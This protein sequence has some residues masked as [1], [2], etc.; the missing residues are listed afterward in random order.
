ML[1]FFPTPDNWPASLPLIITCIR[2][3]H[4]SQKNYPSCCVTWTLFFSTTSFFSISVYLRKKEL[5]KKKL[6]QRRE[7]EKHGQGMQVG[8]G[9]GKAHLLSTIPDVLEAPLLSWLKGMFWPPR[10][11]MAAETPRNIQACN[12]AIMNQQ[13]GHWVFH[14]K[15]VSLVKEKTTWHWG[16]KGG[17]GVK[18]WYI[19]TP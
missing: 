12:K 6:V 16:R 14:Y 8:D 13:T 19:H 7:E 3:F 15:Y 2:I 1:K 5:G 10:A 4:A 18:Q 11:F 17:G 9:N